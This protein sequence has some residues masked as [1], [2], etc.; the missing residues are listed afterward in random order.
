VLVLEGLFLADPRLVASLDRLLHLEAD[1]EL[2][3][4][5][6]AA[7]DG[8]GAALELVRDTFLPAQDAFEARYPPANAGLVLDASN[9]LGG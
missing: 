7:R 9:P 1:S 8:S 5:R 4:A 3:L 2:L 6:A